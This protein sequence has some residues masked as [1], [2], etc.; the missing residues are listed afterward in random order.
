MSRELCYDIS[1]LN[2]LKKELISLS[3]KDQAKI[4]QGFFKTSKGQYGEGD[5]FLGIKVPVQRKVGKSIL[6]CLCLISKNY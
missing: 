6:I 2:K 3:D 5:I 4:L 1:M